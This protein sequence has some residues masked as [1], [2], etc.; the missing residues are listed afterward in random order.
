MTDREGALHEVS[1]GPGA[2]QERHVKKLRDAATSE[3][4]PPIA[5]VLLKT[6]EPFVQV[7]FDIEVPRMAFGRVCLIGDA[8]FTLRP[9]AAAGTAKAAE[10]AWKLGEAVRKMGGDVVAALKRWEPGQ[11][12]LG[13]QVLART[14]DAGRRS[15]FEGTW[16]IGDPLP[17]GLYEVGDS[18]MP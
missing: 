14:R 5:E 4:P 12:E 18:A 17:F 15:Q 8:A 11:L 1:L 9:H 3:L 6:A 7:V 2:V 10:D 13:R 16:R